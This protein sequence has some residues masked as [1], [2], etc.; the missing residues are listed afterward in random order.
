[1]VVEVKSGEPADPALVRDLLGLTLGEARVAALI[2]T[3]MTP[4]EVAQRL[5]ITEGTTRTGLKRVFHKAGVSRQSELAALLARAVVDLRQPR[6]TTRPRP[7]SKD[8]MPRP[9][10]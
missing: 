9:L 3:G 1:M 5:Y 2:A 6:T 7:A 10:T 8:A 4:R